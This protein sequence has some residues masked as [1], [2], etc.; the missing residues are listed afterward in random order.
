MI[1]HVWSGP[2]QLLAAATPQNM[3]NF[4]YMIPKAHDFLIEG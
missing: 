3:D 2:N 4:L 1:L